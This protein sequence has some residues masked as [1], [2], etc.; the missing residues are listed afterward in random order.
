MLRPSPSR[1]AFASPRGT[2]VNAATR[3]HIGTIYLE[4]YLQGQLQNAWIAVGEQN[5]P[6]VHVGQAG[7]GQAQ[8]RGVEQ[9]EGLEAQLAQTGLAEERQA[10]A[11]AERHVDV[12][13]AGTGEGV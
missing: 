6:K 1:M 12:G 10:E 2:A 7:R 5:T 13:V 11:L 8:V 4:R 9:I 3:I